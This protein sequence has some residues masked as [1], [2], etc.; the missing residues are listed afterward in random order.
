MCVAIFKVVLQKSGRYQDF[1]LVTIINE[2]SL[3]GYV[4]LFYFCL[5]LGYAQA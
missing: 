1:K 2:Q 5:M 4:V 3:V